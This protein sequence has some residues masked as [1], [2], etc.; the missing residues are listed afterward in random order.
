MSGFEL[1]TI[2]IK[3]H[4]SMLHVSISEADSEYPDIRVENRTLTTLFQF[5]QKSI[6]R[7]L[8]HSHQIILQINLQICINLYSSYVS[9][10][11]F[12]IL[13]NHL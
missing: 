6:N 7:S 12:Q 8:R 4:H 3:L 10:N 11:F 1:L 2:E 13:L 5:C 9:S